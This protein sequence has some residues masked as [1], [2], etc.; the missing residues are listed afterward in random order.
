VRP[1]RAE[2]Y[3]EGASPSFVKI[4]THKLPYWSFMEAGR[5][6]AEITGH[7]ERNELALLG[8]NDRFFLLT[9]L[10]NR[11]DAIHPWIYDR[12]REVEAEP[13]GYLDL[14]ARYHYKSSVITFAGTVQEILIDPE[15]RVCIF[16]NNKAIAHP[17]VAQI[18]EEFEGNEELKATYSDVLWQNPR[19]EAPIWSLDKGLIV[20]R[21]GNPRECTVEGHGLVDALPTGKHFPMLIYDDVITEKNVTNPAQIKKA[22]ERVELS[23]PCGIGLAT[24]KRFIGTRYSYADAYGHLIEK[25]IAR[26]R[27]YPATDNGKID[28]TP[29]FMSPEA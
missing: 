20:K 16:S 14:W 25:K 6:Y 26:P 9:A 29:V 4:I 7:L 28:G 27:L 18:K 11:V 2:R 24:R 19:T 1:L 12:A 13:D 17:F 21:R 23:F 5:F 15:I 8:C 10:L 3:A 22:S